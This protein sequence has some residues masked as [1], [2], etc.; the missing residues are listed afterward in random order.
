MT[1]KAKISFLIVVWSIVAVQMYVNYR[2]HMRLEQD[3]V[4]AFSVAQ[5]ESTKEM[6]QGYGKFTDME[7]SVSNKKKML[8]NLARKLGITDGYTY[9]GSSGDGNWYRDDFYCIQTDKRE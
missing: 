2:Q 8:E 4:T 5:E 9:S 1:R 3:T 6:I 7:L